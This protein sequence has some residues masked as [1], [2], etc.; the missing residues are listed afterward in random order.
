M[1]KRLVGSTV[2]GVVL[3]AGLVG[4]ISCSEKIPAGYNGIVYSLNGGVTGEI[5]GQGFHFISPLEKV[6]E[7]PVSTETM[8]LSKESVEGSKDDNSFNIS[9]K[10]GKLVNVDV[11][12]SYHYDADMLDEVYTKWRGKKPNEI[13]DTY[14]RARIKAVAN[15]ISSQY[16][17]ID[18]YGEKRVELNTKVFEQLSKDLAVDGIVLET[19]TFTRI[20]PDEQTQKAIQEKVDAQQKLEQAKIEAENV[21]IENEK[22]I[23]K[24]NADAE[25]KLITAKAEADVLRISAQAQKESNELIAQSLTDKVLRLK[26][27]QKWDGKL[28]TVTSD[29]TSIISIGEEQQ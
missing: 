26:E 19:F 29:A 2:L 9:T 8:Y 4:F 7:Y 13:E 18:V 24:A 1:S 3:L 11:E 5:L 21:Q 23:S 12:L 15:E 25:A 16:G 10:D 20:E 6:A 17:V 27:L 14:I 22:K 28:P